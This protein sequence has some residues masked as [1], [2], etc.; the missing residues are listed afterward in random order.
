MAKIKHGKCGT[1]L[2]NVWKSI[3][4]RCKNKTCQDY[5]WYGE[6]GV[7][8]CKEWDDFSSFFEWAMKSGYKSGLTIE[9]V[10]SNGPYSP[11]NCTW[12]TIEKQQKNKCNVLHFVVFGEVHT[13][14]SACKKYG[15]EKSMFYDRKH[16]GWSV[17]R[18]FSTPKIT[19]KGGYRPKGVFANH[20]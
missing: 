10:D 11:E 19:E 13:V 2:Y 14:E 12:I 15:I 20:G 8:V 3:R 5:R 7:F 9:R 17:E 6:K 1:P 4:Q 18:I 16:K